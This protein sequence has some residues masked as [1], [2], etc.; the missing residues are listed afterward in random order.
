MIIITTSNKKN[1]VDTLSNC[2]FVGTIGVS[3]IRT[4]IIFRLYTSGYI[5]TK[6]CDV[7]CNLMDRT[8]K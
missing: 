8:E 1:L 7:A 2:A 6:F 3:D 4:D 5:Q